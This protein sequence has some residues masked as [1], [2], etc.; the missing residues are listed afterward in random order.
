MMFLG[1]GRRGRATIRISPDAWGAS[2]V[3]LGDISARSILCVTDVIRFSKEMQTANPTQDD[4]AGPM[5]TALADEVS[6][7]KAPS[8]VN[9]EANFMPWG[10]CLLRAL[11]GLGVHL[12]PGNLRGVQR[13]TRAARTS[14]GNIQLLCRCAYQ[15]LESPQDSLLVMWAS[16]C[17]SIRPSLNHHY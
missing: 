9:R 15:L 14:T 12:S 11:I 7:A 5:V 13:L 1:F 10:N 2:L 4:S 6:S 8:E 16:H 17:L 3:G